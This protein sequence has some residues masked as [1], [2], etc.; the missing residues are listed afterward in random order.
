MK[1]RKLWIFILAF[2]LLTMT[3]SALAG[4]HAA[5]AGLGSYAPDQQRGVS[6]VAV[7]N[8]AHASPYYALCNDNSHGQGCAGSHTW[9]GPDRDNYAAA[10]ADAD[11]HKKD[12]PSHYVTVYHVP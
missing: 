2:A 1:S 4:K 11:A 9:C 8:E 5:P 10:K 12:N 7:K 6:T 3:A